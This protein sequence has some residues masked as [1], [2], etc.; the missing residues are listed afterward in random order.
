MNLQSTKQILNEVSENHDIQKYVWLFSGG[1]DS[2]ACGKVCMEF[3]PKI[4]YAIFCDT[5]TC[6]PQTKQFVMDTCEK[7]DI[8]LLIGTTTE[9]DDYQNYVLKFGFPG[10]NH[11]QHTVMYRMLKDHSLRR[12][13]SKIRNRKRNYK[14][15]LLTGARYD[16]STRRM[17]TVKKIDARGSD[18]W[19]NPIQDWSKSD[20]HN[21]FQK[22][23]IERSVVAQ[24]IGRSGECNCGVFGNKEELD[25]INLISPEF[26]NQMRELEQKVKANGFCWGWGENPP[27][28][29]AQVSQG[30]M[31]FEGMKSDWEDQQ[32]FMCSTC[33]NNT[34]FKHTKE[35]EKQLLEYK[36]LLKSCKGDEDY[37]LL[38]GKM[39]KALKSPRNFQK[40]P[41]VI[42]KILKE[43]IKLIVNK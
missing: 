42:N 39:V 1:D 8:P 14:I 27:K 34:P 43:H 30:Q 7:M 24:T 41:E 16:E 5:G 12:C 20:I 32:L 13:I 26:V 35:R 3:L 23:N 22:N 15:A 4:D 31:S 9:K 28:N 10:R 18:I 29:W 2:L 38:I 25:E 17:G 40:K 19:I 37:V 11:K 21:Y 33:M 6:I 36:T